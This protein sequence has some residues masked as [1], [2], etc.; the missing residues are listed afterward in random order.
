MEPKQRIMFF[1][2]QDT[3]LELKSDNKMNMGLHRSRLFIETML[4]V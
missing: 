1:Y 3:P 2:K 4:K